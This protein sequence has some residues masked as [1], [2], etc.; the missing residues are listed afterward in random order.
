[1][2][3]HSGYGV[4]DP[5]ILP[6][7]LH[8]GHHDRLEVGGVG[9]V[10]PSAGTGRSSEIDDPHVADFEIF[11]DY[12]LLHGLGVAEDFVHCLNLLVQNVF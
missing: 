4:H 1:M 12:L 11:G 6:L 10:G 5:Y 3:S 8:L 9:H 2:T 7:L